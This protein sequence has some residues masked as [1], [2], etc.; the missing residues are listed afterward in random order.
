MTRFCRSSTRWRSRKATPLRK[1]ASMP[2]TSVSRFSRDWRAAIRTR[3]SSIRS[4]S[5]EN[6]SH[7]ANESDKERNGDPQH[8]RRLS[9]RLHRDVSPS[10]LVLSLIFRCNSQ[11]RS[12]H[13][14]AS[15]RIR[16]G[17]AIHSVSAS[18]RAEFGRQLRS[19]RRL[20]RQR[21]DRSLRAHIGRV[22][23]SSAA[24]HVR[25]AGHGRAVSLGHDGHHANGLRAVGRRAFSRGSSVPRVLHGGSEGAHRSGD[26][27]FPCTHARR[28]AGRA[29]A[30]RAVGARPGLWAR[31]RARRGVLLG[32]PRRAGG[33]EGEERVRNSRFRRGRTRIR[34]AWLRG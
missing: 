11:A 34:R 33:R 2:P 9:P 8:P 10:L 21:G 19:D 1:S 20:R 12:P 23:G 25:S 28:A 3:P 29:G 5:L 24:R 13:R 14:R 6:E 26:G 15:H 18:F 30:T 16:R 22:F 17:R 7:N 32:G 4:N 27:R 31:D